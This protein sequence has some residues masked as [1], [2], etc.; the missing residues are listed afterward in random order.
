[1]C[2]FNVVLCPMLGLLSIFSNALCMVV[3]NFLFVTS[4]IIVALSVISMRFYVK[5]KLYLFCQFNYL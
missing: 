2:L 1:M 3:F 4:T 5:G